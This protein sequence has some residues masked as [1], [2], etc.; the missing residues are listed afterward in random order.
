MR[1]LRVISQAA[2]GEVGILLPREALVGAHGELAAGLQED[3][4]RAA[5]AP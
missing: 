4:V 2:G 5:G 1:L 3:V